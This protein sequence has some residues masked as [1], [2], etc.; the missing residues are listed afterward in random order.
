M[1]HTALNGLSPSNP[2]P[3][4]SGNPL[5]KEA[6]ESVR[7]RGDEGHRKTR[8]SKSTEEFSHKFTEN[9]AAGTGYL[10]ISTRSSAWILWFPVYYFY[11]IPEYVKEWLCFLLT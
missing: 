1:E 5:G 6:E 2:I 7:A 3:K 10:Q 4:I 9:E 11:R 8:P